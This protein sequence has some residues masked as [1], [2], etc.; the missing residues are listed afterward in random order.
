VCNVGE[1]DAA[2]GNAHSKALQVAGVWA[3]GFGVWGLGFGVWGL[4]FGV[5][6][7]G[8]G[9]WGL[10]FGVWIWG[11]CL[12]LRF[13][14]GLQEWAGLR[15]DAQVCIVSAKLEDEVGVQLFLLGV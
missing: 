9:V 15:G 14:F 4:G 1:R 10:G 13:S 3:L 6:G 5:W 8:F 2:A 11:W 12:V 7:L